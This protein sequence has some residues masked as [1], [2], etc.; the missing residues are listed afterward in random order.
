MDVTRILDPLNDAQRE[1]RVNQGNYSGVY[2]EFTDE[3]TNSGV[4]TSGITK[5]GPGLLWLNAPDGGGGSPYDNL[6]V[7]GGTVKFGSSF[8]NTWGGGE[9][10][11]ASTNVEIQDGV[12]GGYFSLTRNLGTGPGEWQFTGGTS[13]VS[14]LQG[15]RVDF[16]F[17]GG[18]ELVWGSSFFK[19]DV[20]VLNQSIGN[21]DDF[22][23]RF[24]LQQRFD[25]FIL[26]RE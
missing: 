15:D 2:A 16:T 17:D 12:A 14:Q 1:I 5:T 24:P 4:G 18:A 22:A 20:F 21:N 7:N 10:Q 8:R 6:I 11:T 19:P 23:H 3:F 25:F 9:N 26:E 13:G